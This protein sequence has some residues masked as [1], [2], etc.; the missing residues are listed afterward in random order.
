MNI[1]KDGGKK[2]KQTNKQKNLDN[3]GLSCHKGAAVFAISVPLNPLIDH[4]ESRK[5]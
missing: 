3:S 4:I 5:N 1:F 2:T